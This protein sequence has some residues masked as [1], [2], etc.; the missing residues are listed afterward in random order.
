[1][2]R[3]QPQGNCGGYALDEQRRPA[4]CPWGLPGRSH[5]AKLNDRRSVAFVR[6]ESWV[7]FLLLWREPKIP[8][9]PRRGPSS[10]RQAHEGPKDGQDGLQDSQDSL[11]K[12]PKMAARC[13][14]HGLGCTQDELGWPQ[15]DPGR[16]I[17][18]PRG[19]QP[20]RPPRGPP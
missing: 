5:R 18:P 10:A 8:L 7:Q 4:C 14:Q 2:L 16:P 17:R 3:L 9:E 11:P 20:K 1:M 12:E 19:L 6:Q 15:D 13:L